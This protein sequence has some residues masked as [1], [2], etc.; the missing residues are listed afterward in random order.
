M[1]RICQW[2]GIKFGS[3]RRANAITCSARCSA[4]RHKERQRAYQAAKYEAAAPLPE[5]ACAHCQAV[6]TPYRSAAKFCSRRCQWNFTTIA[7]RPRVRPCSKCGID[8]PTKPGVPV[9]PNCLVDPR[10]AAGV[11]ERK[12][13]LERYGLTIA[14]YDHM[15]AQQGG[16][17]A[18]CGRTDPG[19][20]LQTHFSVDHCHDSGVVRG[21][22]CHPCNIG[23]GYLQDNPHVMRA[24]AAYVAAESI[25][26]AS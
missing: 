12:R 24:A 8:T 4:E 15:L 18:I 3:E 10:P 5:I 26:K 9:C 23:I 21:L 2:C 14:D 25:R 7:R 20:H 13:N 22:L 17:C 19:R 1:E 11:R 6:F 16:G